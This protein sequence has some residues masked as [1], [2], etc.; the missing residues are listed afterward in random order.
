MRG[1]LWW[2]LLAVS[3]VFASDISLSDVANRVD[4]LRQAKLVNVEGGF[5]AIYA[6]EGDEDPLYHEFLTHSGKPTGGVLRYY[7]KPNNAV[8]WWHKKHVLSLVA[9]KWG[10]P[11]DTISWLPDGIGRYQ[12]YSGAREYLCLES[13]FSGVGQSGSMAMHKAV[14]VL[15]VKRHNVALYFSGYGAGCYM[16]GDYQGDGRLGYV[17][18]KRL[19][20]NDE[21]QLEIVTVISAGRVKAQRIITMRAPKV[22]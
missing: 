4:S 2:L 16:V 13:A 8:Q 9:K 19:T 10:F 7:E 17:R 18:L 22:E 15:D 20:E 11:N 3:P 6:K 21:L 14:L 12:L 1:V 5:H